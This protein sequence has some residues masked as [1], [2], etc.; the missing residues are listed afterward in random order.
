M[1]I[2]KLLG[3]T[4]KAD[5]E[6]TVALPQTSFRTFFISCWM[7]KMRSNVIRPETVINQNIDENWKP[8]LQTPPF[9][10]YTSGHSVS[11]CSAIILTSILETILLHR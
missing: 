11:T 9:P 4:N 6:K 3:I 7:K 1:G 10:E 5:F 2:T 8:L